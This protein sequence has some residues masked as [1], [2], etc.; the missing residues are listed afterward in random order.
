MIKNRI[1]EYRVRYNLKQEDLAAM[2]G[3]CRETISGL[4]RGERNP[5]L[6]LA[7][8]VARALNSNIDEIFMLEEKNE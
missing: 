7:W 5:S 2:V 1:K 8:N 3:V 4:E 6:V